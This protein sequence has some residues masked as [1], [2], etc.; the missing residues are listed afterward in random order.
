MA[1][2]GLLPCSSGYVERRRQIRGT[3]SHFLVIAVHFPS[4][5]DGIVLSAVVAFAVAGNS[6]R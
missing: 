2:S 4:K 6:T 5:T 3:G 1:M